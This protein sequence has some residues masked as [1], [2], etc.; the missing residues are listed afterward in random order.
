MAVTFNGTARLIEV[1][2]PADT[3]LDVQQDIYSAWKDWVQLSTTNGGF[4]PAFRVVGGDPTSDGQNAPIYFFLTNYW[5]VYINN[6]EQVNIELNLYSD[7]FPSPAIVAPGSGVSIKN[8]DASVVT[9][10]SGSGVTEQ[11]KLDIA[12]RVWD[13]ALADHN[14]AGSTGAELTENTEWSKKASDNA[15]QANL[16]L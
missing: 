7:N 9:I 1:T 14:T 12:D 15:E 4:A 6:G 3:S 11:D 2:N 8:S 5:Q 13:E 16:K 10:I